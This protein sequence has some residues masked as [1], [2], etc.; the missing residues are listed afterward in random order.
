MSVDVKLNSDLILPHE[1][2]AANK[3]AASAAKIALNNFEWRYVTMVIHNS[4]LILGL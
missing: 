4:T 3:L 2:N 1:I